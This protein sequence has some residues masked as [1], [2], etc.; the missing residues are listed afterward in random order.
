MALLC[1]VMPLFKRTQSSDDDD[2]GGRKMLDHFVTMSGRKA[3][4]GSETEAYGKLKQL[5]APFVLRR[6]KVNVLSQMLPPKVNKLITSLLQNNSLTEI[7]AL[8]IG[9]NCRACAL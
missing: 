4:P 2:D 5:L 3:S 6:R 9:K 1:F 8:C 7:I